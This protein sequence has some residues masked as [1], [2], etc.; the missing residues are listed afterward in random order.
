MTDL[1]ITKLCAEA[2]GWYWPQEN[3]THNVRPDPIHND[4]LTMEL[5]RRFELWISKSSGKWSVT[6]PTGFQTPYEN[7]AENEDLN[8]AICECVA[9]MQVKR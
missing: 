8:R 2:M 3:N 5:V 9:K 7:S 4:V 6:E 1:E